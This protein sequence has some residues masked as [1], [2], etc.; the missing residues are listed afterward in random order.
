MSPVGDDRQEAAFFKSLGLDWVGSP[1][2][3][4][5]KKTIALIRDQCDGK[6]ESSNEAK[7]K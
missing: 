7:I 1:V 6:K 4:G 5:Q 2:K 3:N